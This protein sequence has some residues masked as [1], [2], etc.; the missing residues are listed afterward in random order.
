MTA[1]PTLTERKQQDR[2]VHHEE[3]LRCRGRTLQVR[4]LIRLTQGFCANANTARG[5]KRL[6]NWQNQVILML[7][8]RP[9]GECPPLSKLDFHNMNPDPKR[10]F[11]VLD[12]LTALDECDLLPLRRSTKAGLSTLKKSA[13]TPRDGAEFV[14]VYRSIALISEKTELEKLVDHSRANN[15]QLNI[16]GML[17]H[18][19]LNFL[20]VLEGEEKVVRELLSTI[21]SDR[22]HTGMEVLFTHNNH[23]RV[24][25]DW[26]MDLVDISSQDLDTLVSQLPDDGSRVKEVF[27]TFY[28]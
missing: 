25:A 10:A 19:D 26:S 5:E 3:E 28:S 16:S 4:G 22:R 17:L 1:I 9:L 27:S 6:F 23:Q 12:L 18:Y 15:A 24:F 7:D 8:S 20:Q 14:A 13:L 21:T 2:S 11:A